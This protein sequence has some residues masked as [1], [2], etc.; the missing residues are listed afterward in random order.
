MSALTL[1]AFLFF[2]HILQQCI[3]E[4]MTDM[5]TS[6]LM[7]MTAGRESEDNISKSLGNKLEKIGLTQTNIMDKIDVMA[8]IGVNN[9]KSTAEKY[10]ARNPYSDNDYTKKSASTSIKTAVPLID[11]PKEKYKQIYK[12]DANRDR[13]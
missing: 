5:N 6:P 2:L 9:R 7:V 12:N 8:K 3:K 13:Y 10:N 4:H 1:L 11:T